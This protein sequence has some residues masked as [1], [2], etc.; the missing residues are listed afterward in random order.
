MQGANDDRA[1]NGGAPGQFALRTVRYHGIYGGYV[2]N[3]RVARTLSACRR[4]R[5]AQKSNRGA[6]LIEVV[7]SRRHVDF[8]DAPASYLPASRIGYGLGGRACS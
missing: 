1:A 8:I 2:G 7:S 3:L 6:G 5:R 4:R